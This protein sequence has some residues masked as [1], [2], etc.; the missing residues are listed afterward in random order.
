MVRGLFQQAAGG[1]LGL[2]VLP[3]PAVQLDQTLI[4]FEKV[5]RQFQGAV[6]ALLARRTERP[7]PVGVV[8]QKGGQLGGLF[9]V[10]DVGGVAGH[11]R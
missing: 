4:G 3:R 11:A 7:R 6:K 1:L 10:R 8:A 5:G 2:G 9:V